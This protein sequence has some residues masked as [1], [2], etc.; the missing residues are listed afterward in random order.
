MLFFFA[1]KGHLPILSVESELDNQVI[2]NWVTII[3][4]PNDNKV[5]VD[6]LYLM[7]IVF[8]TIRGNQFLYIILEVDYKYSSYSYS[9][10]LLILQSP[11]LRVFFPFYTIFHLSSPPSTRRLDSWCRSLSHSTFL[12][13][14]EVAVRLKIIV[15]VSLHY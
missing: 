2:M 13:F 12:K 3:M 5:K 7:K 14:L 8:D 15:Q 4:D 10:S 11:F 1:R 6:W 9:V